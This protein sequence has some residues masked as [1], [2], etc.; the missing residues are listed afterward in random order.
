MQ[1]LQYFTQVCLE[2]SSYFQTCGS[3][4]WKDGAEF[5]RVHQGTEMRMFYLNPLKWELKWGVFFYDPLKWEWKWG[6]FF[7]QSTEVGMEMRNVFLQSTEVGIK[8]R[9]HF[10]WSTEVRLRHGENGFTAD[11]LRSTRVCLLNAFSGERPVPSHLDSSRI[12]PCRSLLRAA[13]TNEKKM[14]SCF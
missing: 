6:V 10:F 2:P 1:L 9:T 12:V 8:M 11:S 14:F 3:S 5:T 4:W 13:F 7:L